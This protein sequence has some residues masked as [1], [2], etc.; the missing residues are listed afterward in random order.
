MGA[1][2]SVTTQLSTT[3]KVDFGQVIGNVG[4][5]VAMAGIGAG[6]SSAIGP[7]LDKAV[8]SI[9]TNSILKE[10]LTQGVTNSVGG[11]V[12]GAGV[13]G[14]NGASFN[15]A[16][17]SGWSSAKMGFAMGATSGAIKGY[18]DVKAKTVANAD[19]A[20]KAQAE[21]TTQKNTAVDKGANGKCSNCGI[22]NN[23]SSVAPEGWVQKPTDSPGTQYSD[24]NNA[25]NNIR[26]MQGNPNSPNPSQQSPYVKFVKNGWHYDVN[27][28][29]LPNGKLPQAHI[30]FNQF[31]LNNMPKF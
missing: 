16:I 7:Y 8:G 25:H 21:P 5:S 4:M 28:L 30:P 19:N 6:I 29:K 24:P 31:N 10:S 9:V 23:D 12:I 3:G 11:F 20:T 26:Y 17:N 27:G 13:A 15:D 18:I 1:G 14:V 2:N 22:V